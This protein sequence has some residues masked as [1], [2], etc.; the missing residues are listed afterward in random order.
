MNMNTISI[1]KK[2]MDEL[3]RI[4]QKL[5]V[6]FPQG[7][8][9]KTE[10]LTS[11]KASGTKMIPKGA[12]KALKQVQIVSVS[13]EDVYLRPINNNKGGDNMEKT[14]EHSGVTPGEQK[15]AEAILDHFK[16]AFKVGRVP[17]KMVFMNCLKTALPS[18][19]KKVKADLAFKKMINNHYLEEKDNKI[20]LGV[21]GKKYLSL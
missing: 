10:V 7:K 6:D 8:A 15:V 2:D 19:N 4:H 3:V 11:I 12:L 1:S 17:S 16:P 21:K 20:I 13:D 18:I 9:S 14:Y 5:T